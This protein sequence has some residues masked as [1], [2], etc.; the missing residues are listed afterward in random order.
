MPYES[1]EDIAHD[2]QTETLAF[3]PKQIEDV[4][5]SMCALFNLIIIDCF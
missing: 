2:Q 3:S 5:S 1:S 4:C